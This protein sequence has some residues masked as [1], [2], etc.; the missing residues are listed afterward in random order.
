MPPNSD[1]A[2][3]LE[4]DLYE[5]HG[6]LLC[7]EA[8]RTA[9]GYPTM[10]A[11]RQALSRRTVPVPVFGLENRRGKYALV[12]DVAVWLAS[13]RTAATHQSSSQAK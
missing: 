3:I 4:Q 12:K 5:R 8:L 7:N 10:H 9:L 13:Q 2:Q 11:F 1:L 6:P